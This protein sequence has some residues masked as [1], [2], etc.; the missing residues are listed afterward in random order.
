MSSSV[1]NIFASFNLTEDERNAGSIFSSYQRLH[2]QNLLSEYAHEKVALK[3][4]PTLPM[5][6]VQ[7]EAELQGKILL[8]RYILET[9]DS[10]SVQAVSPQ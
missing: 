9:S 8:L 10:L 5:Q 2:L 7:Q 6:F 1:T 4:D 3:Y